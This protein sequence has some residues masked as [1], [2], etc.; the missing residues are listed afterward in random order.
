MSRL[1]HTLTVLHVL[2][3]KHKHLYK[4]YINKPNLQYYKYNTCYACVHAGIVTNNKRYANRI[5]HTITTTN[6]IAAYTW[7]ISG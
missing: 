5:H 3:N 7:N 4:K 1:C 6:Q 2:Q